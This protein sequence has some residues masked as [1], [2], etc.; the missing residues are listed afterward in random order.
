MRRARPGD[1]TNVIDIDNVYGG[2]DYLPAIY[3][4]LICDPNYTYYVTEVNNTVVR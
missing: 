2:W 1:K 4:S 3:D